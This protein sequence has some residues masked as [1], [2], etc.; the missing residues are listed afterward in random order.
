MSSAIAA[1]R[2]R[3]FVRSL[4]PARASER[5]L[6]RRITLAWGLLV[7]NVLTFA[8]NESILH[9]PSMIGKGITQGSLPVALLLIL[10][11]NRRLIIRPNF[12]LCLPSLLVIEA[13]VTCL[14]A[15]FLK[16]TVY[17]TF[18]LAEF[19]AALWLLTPFWGRRDMLLIR[20]HLKA[21]TVVLGSVIIGLLVDPG[22]SRAGGRLQGTIWP[23]P[24][25]QVA[26]YAAV[27]FGLVAVLWFC[28]Y[29]RGRPTIF[30]V[31][32]AGVVLILTHTRTALVGLVAGLLVAGLSLIVTQARVR[33]LFAATG[34][35]TAVA[36]LAFSG[37]ITSWLAR[38]QS[39]QELT[40]F[41]GRASVWSQVLAS[42]RTKF[43]EI[44]GFGLSTSGFGGQAIDSNWL[45]CYQQQGLMGVA[46]CATMLVFLFVA[47]CFQ[48]R[49]IQR[50][51]ALFL[52]TYC[53]VASVT[54]VGFTDA[55]TY[56]L[57]LTVAASLLVP[58]VVNKGRYLNRSGTNGLRE[59]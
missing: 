25:P 54:E 48:P 34:V 30:A 26:H 19:V 32:I 29:W 22:H 39:S 31:A 42:P 27:T 51:L 13:I 59:E 56:L 37:P 47:A 53:L 23:V 45:A 35:A 18:R 17:R 12:F 6:E 14:E 52:V 11:V 40:G 28:G 20:C 58:A 15:K 4:T 46:I 24:S 7:L 16:S 55:S 57:D 36:V 21:M 49:G 1:F 41:S 3:P 8:P 50:A 9:I 44:F 38:G 2:T 43:Q 10:T 33:R 5:R